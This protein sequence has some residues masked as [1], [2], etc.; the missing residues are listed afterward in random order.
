MGLIVQK[1]GG[2]SL[3]SALDIKRC[4]RVVADTLVNS[5]VVV[6]VSAMGAFTDQ[7]AELLLQ[8]SSHPKEADVVL[9]SGEQISAGLFAAALCDLGVNAESILGWQ[10]PIFT[11][12]THSCAKIC[13]ISTDI[14][15]QKLKSGFVVVVPGFQG[16]YSGNIT[17]LGR[18]GSDIT[19]LA[20]AKALSAD[21]CQIYTDVD[22]VFPLYPSIVHKQNYLESI[23]YDQMLEM[24][25]GKKVLHNRAIDIA[26]KNN[27]KIS[28]A[29]SF[30]YPR[31]KGT[32]ISQKIE[33]DFF[34]SVT[35]KSNRIMAKSRMHANLFDLIVKKNI[36]VDSFSL[37]R[38]DALVIFSEKD[39]DKISHLKDAEFI[40]DIAVVS[41][42]GASSISESENFIKIITL[43]TD[44]E[45]K[46]FNVTEI[47]VT[48][49]ILHSSLDDVLK[50]LYYFLQEKKCSKIKEFCEAS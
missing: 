14:I 21:S 9:S 8:F 27:L 25:L 38:D 46:F 6:V 23:G 24:C 15:S 42:I 18:G 10:V 30:N 31:I 22:G 4:A 47:K 2:S 1:F 11:D 17:T 19:A 35:Y 41:V 33:E 3:A 48:F 7:L 29:S 16:L 43:L 12:S 34:G 39:Y 5:S 13:D 20:L 50:I 28:V 32:T 26:R 36:K 40:S 44:I 49:A 45:I 37:F